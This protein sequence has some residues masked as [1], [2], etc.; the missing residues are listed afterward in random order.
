M[1]SWRDFS[2]AVVIDAAE[3]APLKSGARADGRRLSAH[4]E[5]VTAIVSRQRIVKAPEIPR[6]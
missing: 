1:L 5:A 6:G 4:A 3:Q 2:A